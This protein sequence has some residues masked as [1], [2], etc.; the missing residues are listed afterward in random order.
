MSHTSTSVK[1]VSGERP[2][3]AGNSLV[4]SKASV[5]MGLTCEGFCVE[6]VLP[7]TENTRP[8]GLALSRVCDPRHT[9]NPFPT[10]TR[11]E[12]PSK[13]LTPPSWGAYT[14]QPL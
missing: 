13:P 12:R 4:S 8:K 14:R 5:A 10:E 9:K 6:L 7:D 2:H 11:P 1:P 3:L